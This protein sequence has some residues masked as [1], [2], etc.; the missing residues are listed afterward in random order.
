VMW[1]V[2][3]GILLLGMIPCTWV[4]LRS[5]PE[6]GLTALS[7]ASVLITMALLL[8]AVGFARSI[9][10]DVALVTALLTFAGGMVFV[11]YLERWG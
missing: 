11:Q 3:A 10:A 2:A 6:S 4:A 8:L 9:Y 1:L 5:D 7:T